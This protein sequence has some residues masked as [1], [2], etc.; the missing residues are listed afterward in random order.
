[1]VLL[2]AL[3]TLSYAVTVLLLRAAL[4][5]RDPH[6]VPGP[7][8][9]GPAV[10]VIIA[11]RNEAAGIGALL[12]DLRAQRYP[13][14]LYEVIVADDG[15][16]D[17]TAALVEEEMARGGFRLRLLRMSEDG[18]GRSPKKAALARAAAV[19]EGD[20]LLFTDGDCRLGPDWVG[21]HAA[22]YAD[23]GAGLVAGLVDHLPR[24]GLPAAMMALDQASLTGTG[25][26]LLRLG[27]PLWANGANLSCRKETFRESGTSAE[28]AALASG[29]DTLLLQRLHRRR[30]GS[31][32]LA[33]EPEALVH[34]AAPKSASAFFHQRLRWAAK[35]SRYLPWYGRALPVYIF[36]FHGLFLLTALLVALGHFPL[37]AWLLL[38][39]MR[40]VAEYFFL[41][42]VLLLSGR[43][44][45]FVAFF[46]SALLYPLYAVVFGILANALPFRWK[47]R[48]F[49]R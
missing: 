33:A 7:P 47:G 1:V 19:A 4:K 28:D 42:E 34:T 49:K 26:A 27:F 17:G 44:V 32:R 30:P 12:G 15:S 11:A 29:D 3:L 43:K 36:T 48:T 22:R 24:P 46:M 5:K 2:L 41:R 10:S 14:R 23:P 16:T 13:A 38:L 25:A 31:L 37:A 35:W 6:P 40:L 18:A 8:S 39:A 20:I 21:R 9:A 45:N